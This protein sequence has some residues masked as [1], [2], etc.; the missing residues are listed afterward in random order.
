MAPMNAE[1][2]GRLARAIRIRQRL[3][4]AA[5]ALRA[6]VSASAVSMLERGGARGMT[7]ACVESILGALGCRTE[8]RVMW[9]GPEL[10]RMLDAAHAALGAVVKKRLESWGWIVRVEV[11]FNRYGERGRIDLLAWHPATG[12]LLVVE[13]K[14]ALVDVQELLGT[15][16]MKARLARHVAGQLGW[17]VRTVVPAIVFAEDRTIRRRLHQLDTL[18]DRFAVRGR[19]AVSWLRRPS[20]VPSGILWFASVP[21]SAA[22]RPS[23]ERVRQPRPKPAAPARPSAGASAGASAPASARLD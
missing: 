23:A 4:Q 8:L 3:T 17:D 13:V 20:S 19:Q 21:D 18:F 5:V 10:D 15:L 22:A 6:G 16:D 14:T 7:I 2:I 1:R 12:I 11:S 9:N